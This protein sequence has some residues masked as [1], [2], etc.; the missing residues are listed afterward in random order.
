VS[1]RCSS[2]PARCL[3]TGCGVSRILGALDQDRAAICAIWQWAHAQLEV[4]ALHSGWNRVTGSWSTNGNGRS[5]LQA[6][7]RPVHHPLASAV[8]AEARRSGAA[9]MSLDLD[10]LDNL[11]S[12]F[13]DLA[14]MSGSVD[15]ALADAVI[16]LQRDGRMVL[17]VGTAAAGQA[18]SAAD[19][20]VGVSADDDEKLPWCADLFVD[21]LA[22]A[23]RL[24]HALPAAAK[25]SQRGVDLSMAASLLGALLMVPGVRGRGPGPVT[26]GAAVGLWTGYSLARKVIRAKAPI[27][28]ATHEWH[29]MSAEQVRRFLP[30][31]EEHGPPQRIGRQDSSAGRTVSSARQ[32]VS[33]FVATLREELSDPLIPVL[34]TGSAASAVLGSPADAVLVGSVLA[35]NSALAATQ[36]VRAERLLRRLLAVQAPSARKVR[37]RGQRVPLCRC[38]SRPAAPRRHDR[39]SS[40]RGDTSRRAADRSRRPRGGRINAHRGG[41][42]CR[43]MVQ[44]LALGSFYD[45]ITVSK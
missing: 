1:T 33:E 36:Q 30:T 4:G 38:R 21:D 35:F 5:G 15:T 24:L 45:T 7:V 10:E 11:R 19:V 8:I 14:P 12:T 28:E 27:P 16:A 25:A 9:V 2:T 40:R 39:G 44:P 6:L 37:A 31:N 26:A 3:W 34:A 20:G 22:G 29:A 18:L 13:D 32:A 42:W 17:V 41:T 43:S 23:R